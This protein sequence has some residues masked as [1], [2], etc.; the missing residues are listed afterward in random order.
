MPWRMAKLREAE[1]NFFASASEGARAGFEAYV[2][3]EAEW[4]EDYALFM[5]IDT[6]QRALRPGQEIVDWQD[7]PVEL[8]RRDASALAAARV[9]HAGELRF[10]RFVQHVFDEQW[11]ILRNYANERNIRD[12]RRHADLRRGARGRL[13]ESAGSGICSTKGCARTWS[14]V[15]RRTS[16]RKRDSAG[17]IRSTTG[18]RWPAM[19]IAGGSHEPAGSSRSRITSV[20]ITFEGSRGTGKFRLPPKLPSRATGWPVRGLRC[21]KRCVQ[22]LA[23]S[24]RCWP[25]TSAS[26]PMMSWRCA[27]DSN[28]RAC[29][30]CSSASPRTATTLSCR[31]TTCATVW[32]TPAR[33]TTT[34]C[35]VGMRVP[36][37]VSAPSRERIWGCSNTKSPSCTGR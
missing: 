32:R 16:F 29:A 2:T 26:S 20:S 22:S 17:V 34:P 18:R 24:C 13:L 28:Y 35:M 14:L 6:E 11:R 8:A 31:T 7:W 36:R 33:T 23:N 30:S 5:A 37:I 27:I 12:R 19:G 25:R 3:A 10:W 21:S 15:C 1:A 4:L 9:R